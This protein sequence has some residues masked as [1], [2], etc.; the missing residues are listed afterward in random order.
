[1]ICLGN[2]NINNSNPIGENHGPDFVTTLRVTL[3]DIYFGKQMEIKYTKQGLCPHCRGSGAEDFESISTCT[4]CN[5]QGF[6]IKRYQVGMGFYQQV[7]ERYII[8]HF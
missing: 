5:G 1:M 3:E 7:Q 6:V 8:F 2:I 4:E